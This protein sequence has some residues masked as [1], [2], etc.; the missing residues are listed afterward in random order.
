[1]AAMISE[2]VCRVL[3]ETVGLFVLDAVLVHASQS[4]ADSWN[5]IAMPFKIDPGEYFGT[6]YMEDVIPGPATD[7]GDVEDPRE[8]V[9][10]WVVDALICNLDRNLWGNVLLKLG[11]RTQR[12]RLI[13]ADQSDCFCGST[14]FADGSWRSRMERQPAVGIELLT[15]A[16][17]A[18]G[19]ASGIQVAIE[20]AEAAISQLGK[21]F[22]QVPGSWWA[23][24]SI[25]PEEIEAAL[26]HRARAL[27]NLLSV[28]KWG[29]FNYGEYDGIPIL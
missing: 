12:Y 19:G 6:L 29:T 21:A 16:V 17:A 8:I 7:F 5:G 10:I 22:D 4:F 11:T 26:W 27:P 1:M 24:T 23:K 9:Q 18:S 13:P 20:K 14:V 28:E 25:K 15:E 3:F 2:V